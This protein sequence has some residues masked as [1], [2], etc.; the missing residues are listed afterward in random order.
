MNS[1]N[2]LKVL[3]R[4]S[5]HVFKFVQL[6]NN[7]NEVNIRNSFLNMLTSAKSQFHNA[8]KYR[9]QSFEIHNLLELG[10]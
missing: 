4:N 5:H 7:M 8:N 2:P 9:I 6:R 3:S 10:S 1:V